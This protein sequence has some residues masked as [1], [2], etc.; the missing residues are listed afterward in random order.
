MTSGTGRSTLRDPAW[1]K[2][3]IHGALRMCPA[4]AARLGIADGA[5]ARI[6]TRRGSA[7]ATVEVTDT[8]QPGHVMLPNGLGVDYPDAQGRASLRGVAPNELTGSFQRDRFA[9][10]P[11]HKTV[12][13]RLELVERSLEQASAGSAR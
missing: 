7:I 9:G 8:L 4:D 10:T 3:D 12:P 5:Q 2:K 6:T 1:R 13:A 11:W